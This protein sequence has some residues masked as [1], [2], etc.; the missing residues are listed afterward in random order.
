MDT[1]IRHAMRYGAPDHAI[2]R[3]YQLAGDLLRPDLC[4]RTFVLYIDGAYDVQVCAD[5]LDGYCYRQ[6]HEGQM[7]QVLD[8]LVCL[9]FIPTPADVLDTICG[10]RNLGITGAIQL[11][12]EYVQGYVVEVKTY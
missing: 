7:E 12:V 1:R 5:F 11:Y 9:S 8:D 10:L 4:K 3:E 2:V 6:F